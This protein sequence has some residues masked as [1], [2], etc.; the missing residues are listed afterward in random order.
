[1]VIVSSTS[2]AAADG[3]T[4][5]PVIFDFRRSTSPRRSRKETTI[6]DHT[7]RFPAARLAAHVRINRSRIEP[8]TR[9]ALR[10]PI[11]FGRFVESAIEYFTAQHQTSLSTDYRVLTHAIRP[12]TSYI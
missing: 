5:L 11:D 10:A 4:H 1:M 3:A 2:A 6:V 7:I 12:L 9:S 8:C